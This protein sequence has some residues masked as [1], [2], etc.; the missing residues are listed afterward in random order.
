MCTGGLVPGDGL[1]AAR[2]GDTC[3]EEEKDDDDEECLTCDWTLF[4]F[5]LWYFL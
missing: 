1:I 4:F 5:S 3:D 2:D